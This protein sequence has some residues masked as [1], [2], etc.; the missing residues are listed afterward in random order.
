MKVYVY[1][2]DVNAWPTTIW[3]KLKWQTNKQKNIFQFEFIDSN[4]KQSSK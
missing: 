1:L 4:V 2:F 3:L